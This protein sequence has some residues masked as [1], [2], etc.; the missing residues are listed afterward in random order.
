[1]NTTFTAI[2]IASLATY[3][4]VRLVTIEEGPFSL[5]LK[6]RGLLDPDVRT[7]VGRGMQCVWCL[8]FWIA[9]AL[10]LLATN[11]I[12]LLLVQGLAVSA[13]VSLGMQYGPMTYDRWRRG[14]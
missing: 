13:L 3:R 7:W 8:S 12:G 9:P 4:V 11:P 10:L 2:I 6:L 5:A 14:K 1:M